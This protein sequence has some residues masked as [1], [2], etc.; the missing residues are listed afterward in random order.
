[1]LAQVATM[2]RAGAAPAVIADRAFGCPVFTDPVAARGWDWLVR[3][4]GQTRFRD[5]SG[6]VQPLRRQ[7]SSAGQR[8]KG[9]GCLFKDAGWRQASAVVLWGR[10]HREP[11][12]LAS[13]LPLGWDLL[14]LYK[15]RTAIEIV[16][17]RCATSSDE[18]IGMLSASVRCF[19]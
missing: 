1:V 18:V 19:C 15:K 4:Q 14:A 11:L 7:V 2:L 3:V 9:R 12:L 13:S 8:W 5:Q 16:P 17:T 10:N 6:R